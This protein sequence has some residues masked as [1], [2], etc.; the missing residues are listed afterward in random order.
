MKLNI[1]L[2]FVLTF[3][4][5]RQLPVTSKTRGTNDD[6]KVG[7]DIGNKAPEI[8]EKNPAG[9]ELSLSSLEGKIVLIDFWASWCGPCRRE[10]PTVVAAY[11][12]YKDSNFKSGKGFTVFS[13]S[14]DKD[15]AALDRSYCRRQT[16]LGKSCQRL[17]IL[18]FKI[19]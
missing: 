19:C 13:V 6:V 11:Q 5:F 17:T 14:L 4:R 9:K 1:I 15:K 3:A 10:N 12:K 18:G 2:L 16:G 7:L 8:Q